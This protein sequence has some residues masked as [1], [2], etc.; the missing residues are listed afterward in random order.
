MIVKCIVSFKLLILEITFSRLF[1]IK[2][3]SFGFIQGRK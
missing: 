3:Y 1:D 2:H